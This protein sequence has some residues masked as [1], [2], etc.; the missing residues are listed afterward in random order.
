M[1][2]ILSQPG[3][4]SQSA[5]YTSEKQTY[6]VRIRSPQYL[7]PVPVPLAYTVLY[8]T[9]GV[10]DLDPH[11]FLLA[12]SGSGSR[13]AKVKKFQVLKSWIF[14]FEGRKLLL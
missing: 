7:F 4:G 14:S 3:G 11:S 9:P 8:F 10:V 1:H 12:G 2:A 13:R 5:S 6:T